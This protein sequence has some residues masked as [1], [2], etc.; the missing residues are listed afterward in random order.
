MYT[1][2]C[3]ISVVGEYIGIW[4][5]ATGMYHKAQAIAEVGWRIYGVLRGDGIVD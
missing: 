4:R 5:A 3:A 1:I 2:R